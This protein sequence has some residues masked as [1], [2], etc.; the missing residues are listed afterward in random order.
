MPP[1]TNRLITISR[2]RAA[3][4]SGEARLN[5]ESAGIRLHELACELG[6][7]PTTLSRWERGITRP[8]GELA[9]RWAELI[10][11]LEVE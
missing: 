9:I 7:S 3:A 1:Q 8:T 6:V 2:A 10:H 11:V 4:R 5:R